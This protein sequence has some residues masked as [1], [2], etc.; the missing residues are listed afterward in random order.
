[1]L[2][3]RAGELSQYQ[4]C[5]VRHERQVPLL[6]D[7][8]FVVAVSGVVAEKTGAARETYN[9]ASLAARSVLSLW[10]DATGRRDATLREAV[11]SGPDAA[12]RVRAILSAAAPEQQPRFDQFVEE[13]FEIIPAVGD[14]LAAGRVDDLSD[15][16]ARSQAGA[17][18]GL[19]NQV[20][21]TVLLARSARELGAVAAS[22]FGAG[23][24]GSVWALAQTARIAEFCAKWRERYV[25]AFPLHADRCQFF[26]T[27]PGPAAFRL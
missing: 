10:N 21:E 7:Y 19:R 8:R 3:C 15:L 6:G 24:G 22:A 2:C 5:P 12:E 25:A 11:Q 9:R 27:R 13:T 20:P 18:R 17:E 26:L 1:M 4:F 16:V 14:L 23:F